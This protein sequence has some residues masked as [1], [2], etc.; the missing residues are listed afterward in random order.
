M[1][2]GKDTDLVMMICT[3]GHVDHGK[4]SLVKQLTGC[5]TDRLRAEKERGLTIELGFAPCMLKGNL[6]IG[7]VDVPGHEKFI[8]NMVSG[9][10]GIDL[11]VLVIAADD[12]IMPQTIE[13]FQIMELLGIKNGIVALTK[14]DLVSDEIREIRKKE[15]S[16]FLKGSFIGDAPICPVSS[17][18]FEG[19]FEFYDTL[20][21]MVGKLVKKRAFG[22]FRMP[23]ERTFSQQGFGV[24]L[25]GIPVEGK[26]EVGEQ[27]EIIPGNH[28]G[29][30][31]GIQVFGKNSKRGGYGQCLALNI[32]DFGKVSPQRGQV[33]CIPGYLKTS[34]V[35]HVKLKTISSIDR[36]LKNA[37]EIKFHTGTS[38][39]TG[40]IFFAEEK[41]IRGG[42]SAFGTVALSTP[43]AATALDRFIIR[44][45]SPA[46]T[47]A[48]GEILTVSHTSRRPRKK[49]IAQRLK[50]HEKFFEG[51][52]AITFEGAKRRI[53]YFLFAEQK[54]GASYKEISTGT[55]LP[56]N[57]VKDSVKE[58]YNDE[59]LKI[60]GGAE[61]SK[62]EY[63]LHS[64]AYRS[65]LSDVEEWISAKTAE[66]K[67]VSASINDLRKEFEWP[68]VLWNTILDALNKGKLVSVQGNKLIL[69]DSL[70][71]FDDKEKQ[72]ISD[73][74]KV[75]KESGYSSPR[76]EELPEL[77]K[78]PKEKIDRILEHLY[79]ECE[80]VKLA[81][82]VTLEYSSYKKAQSEAVR[83][84]KDKG[85]INSADF[86]YVI[87]STRKYALAIL[88]FMDSRRITICLQNHDRKLTPDH[89]RY[90]L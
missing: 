52:N 53:E 39:V 77:V 82:N 14:I 80:L 50:A 21:E 59:L 29:K 17:E 49:R 88:D 9:V 16:E 63:F 44:R 2:A 15:I 32:P 13:H 25:S 36:P 47:I 11:A 85:F 19:Y 70:S 38:E 86:K 75:Y 73:I 90:L 1:D 12:G 79:N 58:L 78:A 84:I 10:S 27:V 69:K 76:P 74:L 54:I 7:I 26:I 34:K 3:A 4:T 89:E 5:N 43:L 20:V 42:Q 66:D 65:F 51:V 22:V 8:K 46:I 35:F 48:G 41:S 71:K 60:M 18:T 37:E 87:K 64:D 6:S 40:K 31:R 62:A 24:I 83:I 67:S 72:L 45:I 33:V 68:Q 61:I 55:L 30:I 81:K 23:I 56:L 28:K 57:V